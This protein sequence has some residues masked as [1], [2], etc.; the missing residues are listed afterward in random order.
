VFP[1][2]RLPPRQPFNSAAVACVCVVAVSAAEKRDYE[3]I[4]LGCQ[5][6]LSFDSLPGTSSFP[7]F[8]I[9]LASG[10]Q[11]FK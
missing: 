8:T 3:D 1:S 10:T 4:F 2:F 5:I 6:K 11:T 9:Q 7:S